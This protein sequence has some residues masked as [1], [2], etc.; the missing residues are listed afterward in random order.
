METIKKCI[1]RI[2]HFL[3][4]H[5]EPSK[6]AMIIMAVIPFVFMIMLYAHASIKR[7]EVNPAD[8]LL[9]GL[10][11][12]V[13][14][15][16][17]YAFQIDERTGKNLFL[18]DTKSSLQR[19]VI[20]TTIGSVFALIWGMAMGVF[21]WIRTMALP[22]IIFIS[23]IPPLAILPIIFITLGVEELGKISLIIIGIS[24]L[25][26]RDIH[27][28]V[29]EI[30]RE[31]ITKALTLGANPFGVVWRVIVPQVMPRFWEKLCV[32]LS[33]AWLFLIAAEAIAS[34]DGLAYRIYLARRYMNMSLI[35]PLVLWI[36]FLGY[37]MN[38]VI[39]LFIR[40]RYRWY[41][42]QAGK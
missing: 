6:K 42:L 27:L 30:P 13:D 26:T 18:L 38:V 39:K 33:P 15:I 21:P 35:I 8:K 7:H 1:R 29:T 34:T 36:T 5:Y 2:C 9:P 19:L 25:M 28:S 40:L 11:Q 17:E 20:G 14:Q 12:M 3:G 31:H 37:G 24:F 4:L 22:F 16:K 10:T 23:I 41:I 32:Y